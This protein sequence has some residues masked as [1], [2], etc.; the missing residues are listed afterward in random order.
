MEKIV[1]VDGPGQ[2]YDLFFL[3]V[4]YFNRDYCLANFVNYDKS[5]EDT[6]FFNKLY[7]DVAPVSE[8]ILPFFRLKEDGRSFITGYCFRSADRVL[9]DG[10]TPL[11]ALFEDKNDL[12]E[13]ML[14]YWFPAGGIDLD[15]PDVMRQLNSALRASSYDDRLKSA[16]FSFFIDTDTALERLSIELEQKE[17]FIRTAAGY[18][19]KTND[20]LSAAID[21][22]A[23]TDDLSQSG[24]E[25]DFSHADTVYVTFCHYAKNC[26]RI[27]HFDNIPLIL[28]GQDYADTLS[29]LNE[30]ND[31]PQLD[32]FGNA[33]AEKNRLDILNLIL[34][35]GEVSIRDVEQELNFSGTNAYYHLSLMIKSNM[36]KTRNRGKAVYYSINRRFFDSVIRVLRR[37]GDEYVQRPCDDENPEWIRR[38]GSK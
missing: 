23:L 28:L 13:K 8:E 18:T 20:E 5:R 22:A 31:V 11:A 35:R 16:L 10:F 21:P 3:F 15:S 30:K 6:D 25:A 1:F 32:V 33:L 27:L 4:L 26:I 9:C 36:I 17:R 12:R 19:I 7:N 34:S 29:Y 2:W 37:Y 24:Y 14:A 38:M